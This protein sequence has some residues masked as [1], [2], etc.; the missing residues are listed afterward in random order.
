M[1]LLLNVGH[2]IVPVDQMLKAFQ[3]LLSK[4][5]DDLAIH[6]Y[7]AMYTVIYSDIHAHA[8]LINIDIII[9]YDKPYC[10]YVYCHIHICNLTFAE[11]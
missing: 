5:L 11:M 2:Y 10:T 8:L 3:K 6:Y 1:I 4:Y 9:N 7:I